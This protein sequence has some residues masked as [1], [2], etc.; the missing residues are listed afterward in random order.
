MV[1]FTD[2]SLPHGLQTAS[3][4]CPPSAERLG[5]TRWAGRVGFRAAVVNR[6]TTTADADLMLERIVY[7]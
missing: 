3:A 6:R 7:R 2:A 1:V 4:V 5:M